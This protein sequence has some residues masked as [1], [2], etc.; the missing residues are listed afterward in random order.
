L[1]RNGSMMVWNCMAAGVP[2]GEPRS[3]Q[4]DKG[5][6]VARRDEWSAGDPARG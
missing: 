2:K 3:P 6:I 5:N 4:G 1:M